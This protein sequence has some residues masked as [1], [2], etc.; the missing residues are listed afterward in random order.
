MRTERKAK[1]SVTLERDL[2]NEIDRRVPGGGTRSQIIEE[3]LRLAAR[4]H[5]RRDLDAATRVYYEGRTRE[6]RDEDEALAE[7]SD[8]AVHERDVDAKRRGRHRRA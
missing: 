6:Q 7:F 4:E 5:A 8:R 3:W 1:V 2:L